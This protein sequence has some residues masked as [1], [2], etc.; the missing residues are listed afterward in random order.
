MMVEI[1]FLVVSMIM[2]LV[3]LIKMGNVIEVVLIGIILMVM[4]MGFVP[5]RIARM[6]MDVEMDV[7]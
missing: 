2:V 7:Y 1:I 4:I 3:Y 6:Q 5:E